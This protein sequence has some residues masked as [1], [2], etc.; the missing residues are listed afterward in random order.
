MSLQRELVLSG[1]V[2]PGVATGV[3]LLVGAGVARALARRRRSGDDEADHAAAIGPLRAVGLVGA[4]AL[5]VGIGVGEAALKGRPA[6]D[7][8]LPT[9][10]TRLTLWVI[11]LAL[12]H[13][14][15]EA[16]IG[17]AGR[18]W[19]RS[20]LAWGARLLLGLGVVWVMTGPRRAHAWGGSETFA[21]VAIAA[22]VLA[23]HQWAMSART[24]SVGV[25]RWRGIATGVSLGMLS[26]GSAAAL[27]VSNAAVSANVAGAAGVS[28]G[29]L[30]LVGLAMPGLVWSRGAGTVLAWGVGS[31]WLGAYLYSD[32][33]FATVCAL[34]AAPLALFLGARGAQ[35]GRRAVGLWI[36]ELALVVVFMGAA[37]LAPALLAGEEGRGESETGP[38][39]DDYMRAF[40]SGG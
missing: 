18:A 24:G 36:G 20:T 32:M 17:R 33:H 31:V 4:L 37:A 29:V 25:G 22:G 6:L 2:W 12:V 3:C 38:S 1:V 26:G 39:A 27:L 14:V 34:S 30:T 8:L 10:V 15:A 23:A 40:G 21:T 35:R 5:G 7:G 9:D 28:V 13:A 11:G 16:F 19:V